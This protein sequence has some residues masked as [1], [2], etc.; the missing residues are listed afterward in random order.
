MT[1]RPSPL[2]P[3]PRRVAIDLAD[4]NVISLKC[5][6]CGRAYDRVVIF[7]TKD[8]DAYSVVSVV[9]HGHEGEVWLDA[10]FGSWQEPYADHVTFSCRVH[11]DGAGLVDGPVASGGTSAHSGTMLKREQALDHPRLPEVWALV[12][13][14][15]VAVPQVATALGSNSR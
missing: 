13:D 12:D 15:V 6:G 9:C 14:V 3:Y 8:T 11:P 7:A 5:D 10:T 2:R 1:S 4:R